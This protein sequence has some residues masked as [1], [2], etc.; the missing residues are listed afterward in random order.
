MTVCESNDRTP[1][2]ASSVS[3]CLHCRPT[4]CPAPPS[5]V[6]PPPHDASRLHRA[7]NT[8]IA[9]GV[10]CIV[11]AY[12]AVAASSPMTVWHGAAS[13]VLVSALVAGTTAALCVDVIVPTW[14]DEPNEL[15]WRLCVALALVGLTLWCFVV[16]VT[17]S[18]RAPRL[19]EE[20]PAC[21]TVKRSTGNRRWCSK[22]NAPKPDRCHHCSQCGTCV[23]KM[24]HHCPWLMDRCIALRN[25][26]SFLLFLLYA[27]ALCMYEAY[28][29]VDAFLTLV[30]RVRTPRAAADTVRRRRDLRPLARA[31]VS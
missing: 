24:D 31:L 13:A 6:P 25:Y 8:C 12:I 2:M 29:I 30:H 3:G 18:S 11:H 28:T 17:R 4:H 22:C 20:V 7:R 10:L 26:K 16:V 9:Q 21:I 14:E 23:L 19:I 27:S 1:R 5:A 15:L